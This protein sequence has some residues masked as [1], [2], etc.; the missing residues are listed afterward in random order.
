MIALESLAL[1]NSP[2]MRIEKKK[3]GDLS[4][5]PLEDQVKQLQATIRTLRATLAQGLREG[6]IAELAKMLLYEKNPWAHESVAA[7]FTEAS[8]SRHR[9]FPQKPARILQF[10]TR[11][12]SLMPRQPAR[13]LEIGIK[14]GISLELWKA[15]FPFARIVGADIN[16]LTRELPEGITVVQADQSR[17]E[18]I[19]ALGERFGPFDFVVDDGS[20]VGEHMINS[21]VV[22]M[23][24]LNAG[25][26]Y[27]VEDIL[28]QGRDLNEAGDDGK[29]GEL[30]AAALSYFGQY[31]GEWVAP[32]SSIRKE[33]QIIF[34][35]VTTFLLDHHVLG[36]ILDQEPGVARMVGKK[37]RKTSK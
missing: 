28:A 29:I 2:I 34:P 19:A 22:L 8:L 16:P 37:P 6:I 36:F 3:H 7:A 10:Y 23:P 26:L 9:V 35:R 5:L 25:C 12:F 32:P 13:I 14:T 11:A 18:T 21:L 20:H 1:L 33:A 31:K 24:H 27:V 30:V 17:P 4:G 15:I